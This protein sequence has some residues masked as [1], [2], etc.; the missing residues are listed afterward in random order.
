MKKRTL[1]IVD[2]QNDFCNQ[3]GSLY[4]NGAETAKANII[5]YLKSS[6]TENVS[7]ILTRDWHNVYDHSFKCNGGIWPE[8]CVAGTWGAEVDKDIIEVLE[9]KGFNYM[10]SNKGTC[11]NIEEYGAFSTIYETN[12]GVVVKNVNDSYETL[13]VDKT[14]DVC[15]IAGDYCVYETVKN[16]K[17]SNLL[18]VRVLL[19]C[20]ASI[21]GGTKITNFVN[22]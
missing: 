17:E 6:N 1:V 20:T 5:A 8:H 13:I 9:T 10:Y 2:F 22:S 11:P 14:V 4:V 12:E 7:V 16:L 3:N 21:D 19:D 18:D 15:G